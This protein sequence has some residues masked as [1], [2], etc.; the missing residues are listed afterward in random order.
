VRQPSAGVT[1]IDDGRAVGAL[2]MFDHQRQLAALSRG[3]PPGRVA[4]FVRTGDILRLWLGRLTGL[5]RVLRSL[6]DG[7][8]FQTGRR[9]SE[10]VALSGIIAA[11]DR[12]SRFRL[13]LAR[14]TK[15]REFDAD[16][17]ESRP[18]D[19]CQRR[20][21]PV[22]AL[23]RSAHHHKLRI[24]KFDTH[25]PTLPLVVEVRAIRTLT[26]TS[27]GSVETKGAVGSFALLRRA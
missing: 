23:C 14:Q 25:D 5:N 21:A 8:G 24:C 10:R 19:C 22:L 15:L 13:N 1:Q 7:D 17:A 11:P 3:G 12:R 20:Q 6:V 18:L 16:L 26:R 27:P 9:Q 4:A 2:Q